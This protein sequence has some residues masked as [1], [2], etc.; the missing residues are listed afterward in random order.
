MSVP[1]KIQVDPVRDGFDQRPA[2]ERKPVPLTNQRP[3]HAGHIQTQVDAAIRKLAVQDP[4]SLYS[5]NVRKTLLK[6]LGIDVLH[7]QQ[8]PLV[9]P[10]DV[11]DFFGTQGA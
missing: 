2:H 9:E 10:F 7:I 6:S 3:C 11:I 4:V 8:T 5:I 1:R